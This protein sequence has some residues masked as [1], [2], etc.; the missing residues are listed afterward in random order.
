MR[1]R[2]NLG[3]HRYVRQYEVPPKSPRYTQRR[4]KR[5]IKADLN[6][7]QN[8][9]FSGIVL[10][11]D[12]AEIV[13]DIDVQA[14][15]RPKILNNDPCYAHEKSCS[16]DSVQQLIY[17]RKMYTEK[18]GARCRFAIKR[19]SHSGSARQAR[20]TV[21][22]TLRRPMLVRR[23]FRVA[24]EPESLFVISATRTSFPSL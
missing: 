11:Y 6:G 17:P 23:D 10:T 21:P 2:S 7:S 1:Q 20:H 22:R 16:A 15:K 18:S 13:F 9:G 3:E 24:R 14:L 12:T 19:S 5:N 4:R 8:C